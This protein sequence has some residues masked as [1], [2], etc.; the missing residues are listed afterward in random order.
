MAR[1][2]GRFLPNLQGGNRADFDFEESI[3]VECGAKVVA[4]GEATGEIE[5]SGKRAVTHCDGIDGLAPLL[6]AATGGCPERETE[7]VVA[8]GNRCAIGF[9]KASLEVQQ[10]RRNAD[11]SQCAK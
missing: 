2:Y 9:G 3:A 7:G 11:L 4:C 5:N 10:G 6:A 8:I 1:K